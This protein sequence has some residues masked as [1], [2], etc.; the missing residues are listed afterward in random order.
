MP[1]CFT[2]STYVA[3]HKCLF[4]K[5]SRYDASGFEEANMRALAAQVEQALIVM[6]SVASHVEKTP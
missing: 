5:P 4:P 2:T 6:G 1:A 3:Q